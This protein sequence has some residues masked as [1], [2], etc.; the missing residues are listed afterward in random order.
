[1]GPV[2]DPEWGLFHTQ[3]ALWDPVDPTRLGSLDPALQFRVNGETYRFSSERNLRR[4]MLSPKTW[5]GMLRDPVSGHRFLPTRRSPEAY[6]I[7][8]PYFFES[9]A[10]KARFVEDPH[11]YEVIRRM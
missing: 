4:F 11:R 7:G 10:T 5:C 9:E 1:L 8:G 6:W 3:R 2:V